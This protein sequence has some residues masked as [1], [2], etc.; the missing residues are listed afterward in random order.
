MGAVEL[1]ELEPPPHDTRVAMAAP[2]ATTPNTLSRD[3]MTILLALSKG[4]NGH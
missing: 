1:F 2:H 4:R 3:F